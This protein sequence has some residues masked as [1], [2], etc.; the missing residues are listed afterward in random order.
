[1]T[2]ARPEMFQ[3]LGSLLRG[4][5]CVGRI[6]LD[7]DR[8]LLFEIRFAHALD[9]KAIQRN[10]N[11]LRVS[12]SPVTTRKSMVEVLRFFMAGDEIY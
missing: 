10:M 7:Q 3:L 1:M 6:P 5:T 2:L 12:T 8:S 11:S 4:W 9:Q